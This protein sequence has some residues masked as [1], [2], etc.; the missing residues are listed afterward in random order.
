MATWIRNALPRI[1]RRYAA[2][3]AGEGA[4]TAKV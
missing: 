2:L 1:I 3:Y 4:S